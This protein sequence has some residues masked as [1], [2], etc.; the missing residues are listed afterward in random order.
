MKLSFTRLSAIC[1]AMLTFQIS[2]A[3]IAGDYRSIRPNIGSGPNYNWTNVANWETY[4]GVG[5]I[6]ASAYPTSTD[7]TI[8]ISSGDSITLTGATPVTID[9]VVVASGAS[10]IVFSTTTTVNN[11]ASGDDIVVNGDGVF[12]HGL[13]VASGGIL[14]TSTA[15]TVIINSGGMMQ[16][17]N[18]NTS[19][20]VQVN[21]TNNG[22]LHFTN[23]P[24]GNGATALIT[25]ATF[26]NNGNVIWDM[27]N[28][29]LNGSSFINNGTMNISSS[30]GGNNIIG[31]TG[32]TN[33]FTNSA[34]GV[35]KKLTNNIA[36]TSNSSTGVSF[37]NSGTLQ[38]IGTYQFQTIGAATV[39]NSGTI[40]PGNST[41]IL[42]LNSNILI[43]AQTP[44][45][46]FEIVDGT[47]PGTGN[48]Q[49]TITGSTSVTGSIIKVS[50]FAYAAPLG[51][52]TV[53]T[54]TGT[55]TGTAD[56]S[57]LPSNYTGIQNASSIQVQKTT[58]FPLP[59]V[60]GNFTALSEN[61]YVKINWETL[62]EFNTSHFIVEYSTDGRQF[63]QL[64]S[65]QGK[66][67][68]SSASEYYYIHR[69]P[70]LN[71]PNFYRIKQVDLD[72]KTSYSAIRT[73]RFNKGRVV[74]I[75]ATPNPVHNTLQLSV[76]VSDVTVVVT[77]IS[78]RAWRRLN[79][80]RGV[81]PLDMSGLPSGNYE[82]SV[83]QNGQ[84]I[85]SQKIVKL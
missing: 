72:G 59:V 82:L 75:L 16:V 7:G 42:N 27:G 9:Q 22:T 49:I 84:K 11:D 77:D 38:G 51:I 36:G 13:Y 52:Y 80:Q 57:Q 25:N 66:G 76:Q 2:L 41:G 68:S 60:W 67:N 40:T 53:M 14:T 43:N 33:S 65:L 46:L 81:Q 19:G 50:D 8:T 70:S 10:L 78:G 17:R 58:N 37:T 79:V 34:T 32:G 15:A 85:Q 26:T 24:A 39:T 64:S 31:S 69:G 12:N 83:Y 62:Q 56:F 54:T 3:Q 21:T 6:A 55:F 48:D 44:T 71:A 47:G 20:S 73:V 4:N 5:W 30:T 63:I 29:S 1:L 61:D 45:L 74:A 18:Q 28:L 23:T 35:I